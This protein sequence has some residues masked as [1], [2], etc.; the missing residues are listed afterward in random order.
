MSIS[1]DHDKFQDEVMKKL[2]AKGY[3]G[4]PSGRKSTFDEFI[5]NSRKNFSIL[6]LIDF[7]IEKKNAGKKD[8]RTTVTS[9]Q[10]KALLQW[11][12]RILFIIK[13]NDNP[14]VYIIIRQEAFYILSSTGYTINFSR[15]WYE[16]K[17]LKK[18]VFFIC[19]DVKSLI[20]IL[21]KIFSSDE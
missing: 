5:V 20:D 18:E 11:G 21:L 8:P 6:N 13:T 7:K 15:K 3:I 16:K 17:H 9:S 10:I 2:Q 14:C 1:I 12:H 19:K 4:I